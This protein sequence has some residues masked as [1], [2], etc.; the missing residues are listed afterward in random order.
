MRR[1]RR[2]ARSLT[3]FSSIRPTT[4][5]IGKSSAKM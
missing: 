1:R 3:Y 2:W 5:E 4:S